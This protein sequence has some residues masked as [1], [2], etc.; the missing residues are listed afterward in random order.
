MPYEAINTSNRCSHAR[1][2]DP[3]TLKV[4]MDPGSDHSCIHERTLPKGAAPQITR[5]TPTKT[6]NGVSNYNR[7][8]ELQET[9]LPE[10]SRSKHVDRPFKCHVS[11]HDSKVDMMLGND[12]LIAVGISR[13]NHHMVGQFCPMQT[14]SS[15]QQRTTNVHRLPRVIVTRQRH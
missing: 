2:K 8:V 1:S 6:L 9:L 3:S 4:L 5:P 15:L 12:F 13:P 11:K 10:F 7:I 14:T